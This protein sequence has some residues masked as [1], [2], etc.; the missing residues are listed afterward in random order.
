ME[1]K[2]QDEHGLT[3]TNLIRITKG[4]GKRKKAIFQEMMN[5]IVL[6]EDMHC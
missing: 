6:K 2:K 4:K 5:D 1:I 3:N